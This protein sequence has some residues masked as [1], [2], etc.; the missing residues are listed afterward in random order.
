MGDSPEAKLAGQ[1]ANDAQMQIARGNKLFPVQTAFFIR[2]QSLNDLYKK[3]NTLNALLLSN[4]IQ[5]I[6]ETDDLLS[7]DSYVRNLP[8][9][10]QH[11]HDQ[12]LSR[13]SRL[14][15][16]KHAANLMPLYG[17]SVGTGN[18]GI[19]IVQPRC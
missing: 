6:R 3:V 8:M 11:A 13:R 10:Y 5:P 16:S 9:N 1:D 14:M 2:G 15:F 4:Q 18:P 7:L 12:R 17:R 19:L